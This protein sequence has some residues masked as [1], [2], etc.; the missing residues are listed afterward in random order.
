MNIFCKGPDLTS[1]LMSVLVRFRMEHVA[2]MADIESMFHQVKVYPDDCDI[3]CSLEEHRMLV[4]LF[5]ATSS[6]SCSSYAL[7]KCAEDHKDLYDAMT[8]DVVYN[9]VYVDDCLVSVPTDSDAV[10][11]YQRLTKMCNRGGF[12]LT[13]WISNSRTVLDAIPEEVRDKKV[14][15]LDLEHDTLPLERA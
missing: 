9:N 4:H 8:V 15:N 10:L 6:P 13:K 2:V 11:L 7:R 3:D 14:K 5:G 12:R 1:P